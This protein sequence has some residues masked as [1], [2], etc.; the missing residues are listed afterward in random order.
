M[1][2]LLDGWLAEARNSSQDTQDPNY[3]RAVEH[4]IEVMKSAPD[5]ESAIAILQ[6]R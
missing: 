6:R 4:S 5:V 2:E 1:L 3:I